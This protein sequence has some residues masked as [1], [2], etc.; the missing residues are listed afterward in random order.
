[1]SFLVK[2]CEILDGI[3]FGMAAT[4]RQ[5]MTLDFKAS[6][7][8]K[9][10]MDRLGVGQESF[11]VAAMGES[12]SFQVYAKDFVE[13]RNI[14]E[15]RIKRISELKAYYENNGKKKN[16][17]NSDELDKILYQN[18]IETITHC[19]RANCGDCKLGWACPKLKTI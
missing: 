10:R 16:A 19:T 1:M 7:G 13:C 14:I 8:K 6:D 12:S 11:K 15:N 9:Y 18:E 17:V 2:L 3:S 4:N 5:T